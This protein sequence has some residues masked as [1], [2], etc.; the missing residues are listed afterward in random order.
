MVCRIIYD[1][2][3]GRIPAEDLFTF[4]SNQN[5]TSKSDQLRLSDMSH[6]KLSVRKNNATSNHMADFEGISPFSS[7]VFLASVVL[8]IASV[9]CDPCMICCT[10]SYIMLLRC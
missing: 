9:C 5:Y 8:F 2:M 3:K 7:L 6:Q 10:L 1:E 4:T